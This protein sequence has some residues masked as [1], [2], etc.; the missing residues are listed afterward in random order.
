MSPNCWS[1]HT[2]EIC[3]MFHQPMQSSVVQALLMF[4]VG[5][6]LFLVSVPFLF[7]AVLSEVTGIVSLWGLCDNLSE[8]SVNDVLGTGDTGPFDPPCGAAVVCLQPRCCSTLE[9]RRFPWL[10][11]DI[12][13][14]RIVCNWCHL[15]GRVFFRSGLFRK[16]ANLTKSAE[17]LTLRY[18]FIAL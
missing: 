16:K 5:S 8:P 14:A 11:S 6:F 3:S 9:V 2:D 12:L 17:A 7:D 4:D 13:F 18:L 15:F 1:N 10:P